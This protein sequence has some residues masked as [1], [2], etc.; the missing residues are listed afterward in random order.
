MEVV[1]VVVVAI[2][3]DGVLDSERLRMT[4]NEWTV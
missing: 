3:S 1:V 4:L 2:E